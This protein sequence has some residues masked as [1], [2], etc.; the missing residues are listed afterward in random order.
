METVDT[1]S[2]TACAVP[3]AGV[4]NVSTSSPQVV[5]DWD[6]PSGGACEVG[7]SADAAAQAFRFKNGNGEWRVQMAFAN[8][9][10]NRRLVGPDLLSARREMDPGQPPDERRPCGTGGVGGPPTGD[11]VMASHNSDDPAT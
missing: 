5:F 9:L 10:G 7:D 3:A 1:S 11:I 6:A 4:C 2:S 8:G